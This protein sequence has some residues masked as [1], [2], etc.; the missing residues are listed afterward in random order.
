MCTFPSRLVECEGKPWEATT[1]V[2]LTYVDARQVFSG[3]M[4]QESGNQ[5]IRKIVISQRGQTRAYLGLAS[6][7]SLG[8]AEGKRRR[9]GAERFFSSW[10]YRRQAE[11]SS[12]INL[13]HAKNCGRKS[14]D[15]L[16]YQ[17]FVLAVL[18]IVYYM[19][20]LYFL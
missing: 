5:S 15:G 12:S 18:S 19:Y 11:S 20:S 14:L 8:V 4:N 17:Y 2:R 13:R 6:E 10:R 1:L 9:E 7:R 16:L 3:L